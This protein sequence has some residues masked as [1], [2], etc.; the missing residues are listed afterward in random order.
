[1]LGGKGMGGGGLGIVV[2]PA[3]IANFEKSQVPKKTAAGNGGDGRIGI[4]IYLHHPTVII[5]QY[6]DIPTSHHIDTS[7]YANIPKLVNLPSRAKPKVL[8]PVFPT[9]LKDPQN[10]FRI[11]KR[12]LVARIQFVSLPSM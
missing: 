11:E 5:Y 8:I 3:K 10:T 9:P 4:L 2:G 7:V 6:T 1:M 12:S